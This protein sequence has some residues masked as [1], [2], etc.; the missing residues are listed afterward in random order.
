MNQLI[1][2]HTQNSVQS[3]NKPW[4][5]FELVKST[6]NVKEMKSVLVIDS[7]SLTRDELV[8]LISSVFPGV[9]VMAAPDGSKGLYLAYNKRPDVILLEEELTGLD[10][11][12]TAKVLR[13]LPET[14]QIPLI[15]LTRADA[16]DDDQQWAGFKATCHASLTKPVSPDKLLHAIITLNG[17]GGNSNLNR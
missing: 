8:N 6:K 14:R 13:H 11:F 17:E 9:T 15:A 7:N 10:S 3:F 12:R 1:T 16:P 4:T 2:E 5:D